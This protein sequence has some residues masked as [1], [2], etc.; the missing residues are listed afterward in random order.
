[1]SETPQAFFAVGES[2]VIEVEPPARTRFAPA[3]TPVFLPPGAESASE[4][5]PP[6][7]SVPVQV[8]AEASAVAM[9]ESP[10]SQSCASPSMERTPESVASESVTRQVSE[11]VIAT[12]P[13][14]EPERTKFVPTVVAS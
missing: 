12:S 13:S 8:M 6:I 7:V 10:T 1:M 9:D 3:T 11:A 14:I 4:P 5:G 2:I